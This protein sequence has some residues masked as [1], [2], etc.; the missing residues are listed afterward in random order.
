VSAED[1]PKVTFVFGRKCVPKIAAWEGVCSGNKT[2][3]RFRAVY[4]P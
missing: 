3:Q 1:I 2:W 4:K